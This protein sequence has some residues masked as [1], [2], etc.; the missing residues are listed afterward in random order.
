M[1]LDRNGSPVMPIPDP[2][3]E[4]ASGNTVKTTFVASADQTGFTQV[5][6]HHAGVNYPV[7]ADPLYY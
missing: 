4:D 2:W 3:A 6:E 1:L 5:V 7:V